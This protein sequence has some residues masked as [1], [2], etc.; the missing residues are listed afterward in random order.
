MSADPAKIE[1]IVRLEPPKN[2]SEVKSFLQMCQY[3]AL[4]MFGGQATYSDITAPLRNLLRKAEPYVWTDSCQNAFE[5]LKQGLCSERVIAPWAPNRE[6]KLV[7]DRGPSG[8]SATLYQK[9]P[10]TKI[11]KTINYSS[12]ALTKTEQ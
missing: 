1:T 8:I 12:R 7:V 10:T 11:W 9:N 4:F 2:A 6:T 3:N 5:K